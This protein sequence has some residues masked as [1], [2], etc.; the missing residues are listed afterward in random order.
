ME[1]RLRS[2]FLTAEA[3]ADATL[4]DQARAVIPLAAICARAREE[5]EGDSGQ[6]PLDRRML[7]GLLRWFKHEFF[8]WVDAPPCEVTGSPTKPAGMAQPTHEERSWGASRVEI[9]RNPRTG[10][11]TR[12]PR[13]NHPGKLLSTRRGRCGEWANCF[14]LC[15]RAVGFEARWVLDVT[16]HVWCE[17]HLEGRW[18]HC[19]PCECALDAP[20]MYERGWGK[21]L[22]YVFAFNEYEVTDVTKRYALRWSDTLSRL[23]GEVKLAKAL[24]SVHDS[25]VELP[26]E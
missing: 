7:R 19:D 14:C 24:R 15:A 16:D 17:V 22:S 13:Y 6:P 1:G 4:Q 9:Y 26:V 23:V 8:S 10:H 11:I 2:G 18:H 3:H 12:F 5:D 25:H 20:L 21:R